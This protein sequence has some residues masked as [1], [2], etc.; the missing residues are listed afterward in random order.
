M[1]I[2]IALYGTSPSCPSIARAFVFRSGDAL[3]PTRLSLDR[4]IRLYSLDCGKSHTKD[5]PREL[6]ESTPCGHATSRQIAQHP[7]LYK[8][9]IFSYHTFTIPFLNR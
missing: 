2:S 8:P 1:L 7:H 4:T 3:V 6:H 9:S 5:F